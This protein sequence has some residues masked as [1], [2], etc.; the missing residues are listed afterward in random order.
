MSTVTTTFLFWRLAR[1]DPIKFQ[2]ST[3]RQMIWFQTTPHVHSSIR[4]IL[5]YKWD[6][7]LPPFLTLGRDIGLFIDTGA[8]P[9]YASPSQEKRARGWL[10]GTLVPLVN[11][12]PGIVGHPSSACSVFAR[13]LLAR[14]K[15][16]TRMLPVTPQGHGLHSLTHG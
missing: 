2:T 8:I 10:R 9:S 15:Q 6:E 12:W 11:S 14:R 7:Y 13:R 3:R 5:I 16:C 1:D 4:F